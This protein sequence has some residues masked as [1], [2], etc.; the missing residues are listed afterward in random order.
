[1]IKIKFQWY[2]SDEHLDLFIE[3]LEKDYIV[4]S[5][6][7]IKENGRTRNLFRYVFI[8][9]KLKE[10]VVHLIENANER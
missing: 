7:D 4:L 6:S 5:I 8:D 10:K 3:T 1:M 9:C 2:G